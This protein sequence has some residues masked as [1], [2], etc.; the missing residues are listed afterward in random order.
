MAQ[1][2]LEKIAI[3]ARKDNLVKNVYNDD[4]SANNYNATNTRALSDTTTPIQGKGTGVFLD[5]YNGGGDFDI[6]GD[7]AIPGTGRKKNIGVNEYNSINDYT[8]P[9]TSLNKGQVII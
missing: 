7:P 5:I 2:E 8:E 3:L 4:T 9:D 6:N 1:S